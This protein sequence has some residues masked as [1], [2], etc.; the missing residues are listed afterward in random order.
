M[1]ELVNV[2][3][4]K[5]LTMGSARSSRSFRTSRSKSI[6]STGKASTNASTTLSQA[7]RVHMDMRMAEINLV[8]V[9]RD[10]ELKAEAAKTASYAERVKAEAERAKAEAAAAE[11]SQRAILEAETDL[12]MARVRSEAIQRLLDL[13]D[14]DPLS[15]D[16]MV[17]QYVASLP[18]HQ[19]VVQSVPPLQS[20]STAGNE[21]L[22]CANPAVSV[23]PKIVTVPEAT[24]CVSQSLNV[25]ATPW[26]GPMGH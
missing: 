26:L 11:Q 9:K 10:E 1:E 17:S 22:D 24:T 21:P 7:A 4:C 20:P 14:E 12:A 5:V 6:R 15:A 25:Q 16:E 2:Y 18:Q 19:G 8:K 3:V 23:G 13:E